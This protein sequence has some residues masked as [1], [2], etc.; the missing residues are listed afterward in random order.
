MNSFKFAIKAIQSFK[1]PTS[2]SMKN[3]DLL[4]NLISKQKFSIRS[5]FKLNKKL[6]NKFATNSYLYFNHNKRHFSV[7]II[8][9]NEST[10]AAEN[11]EKIQEGDQ[12]QP[13]ENV[14][15]PKGV[16]E[17]LFAAEN[18]PKLSAGFVIFIFAC[19]IGWIILNWGPE[20]LDENGRPIK[21]EFSDCKN[22]I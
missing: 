15:K 10:K 17:R 11:S 9:L 4:L 2:L 22:N 12:Q 21:D 1:Q 14:N 19:G 18:V 16:F 3:R 20:Q 7:S 13:K 6:E 5:T 8:K